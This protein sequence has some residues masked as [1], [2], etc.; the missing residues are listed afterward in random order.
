M[1]GNTYP[2]FDKKA[3]LYTMQNTQILTWTKGGGINAAPAGVNKLKVEKGQKVY[4]QTTTN[5]KE[6]FI[7]GSFKNPDNNKVYSTIYNN[8]T[9]K[10]NGDNGLNFQFV[11]SSGNSGYYKNTG[12]YN[13]VKEVF[14]KGNVPKTWEQLTT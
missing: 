12:F 1:K 11:E 9:V 2:G 10:C 8:L 13:V 3:G 14:C 6:I 5:G 7:G 4:L